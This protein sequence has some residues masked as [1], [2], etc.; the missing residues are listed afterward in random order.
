MTQRKKSTINRKPRNRF[1]H[2][3]SHSLYNT[4]MV[5]H[6]LQS[7]ELMELQQSF[8][9]SKYIKLIG[10]TI[11]TINNI[12]MFYKKIPLAGGFLKIQRPRHLPPLSQLAPILK[13]Y[14]VGTIAIE[15]HPKENLAAY[16]H[17]CKEV[18]KYCKVLRSSYRV[19]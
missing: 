15:P 19:R 3:T 8:L 14:H 16:K 10:W 2:C 6:P 13:E 9:Y 7:Q 5:A 1:L 12:R 17:W 18:S 4:T 11:I